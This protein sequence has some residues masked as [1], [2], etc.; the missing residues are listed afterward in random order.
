M[1]FIS[2]QHNPSLLSYV[3]VTT[4]MSSRPRRGLPPFRG[5]CLQKGVVIPPGM[6]LPIK[7]SSML[8]PLQASTAGSALT[9]PSP[10]TSGFSRPG[11]FRFTLLRPGGAKRPC[12]HSWENG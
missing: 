3:T 5:S 2:R 10:T 1:R 4:G 11:S 12:H 7:K 6:D 9:E 8:P